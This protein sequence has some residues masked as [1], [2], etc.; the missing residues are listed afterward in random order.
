MVWKPSSDIL[1]NIN[2]KTFCIPP[3]S[4]RST[5]VLVEGKRLG[6]SS[7]PTSI[8]SINSFKGASIIDERDHKT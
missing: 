6:D 4:P 2:E 7:M 3:S 8:S 5:E 1:E